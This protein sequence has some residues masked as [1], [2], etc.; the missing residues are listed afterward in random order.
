MPV[1]APGLLQVRRIADA[2]KEAEQ[3][4]VYFYE[5]D[6]ADPEVGGLLG[7]PAESYSCTCL[8]LPVGIALSWPGHGMA[9]YRRKSRGVFT[10]HSPVWPI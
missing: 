7:L 6:P 10:L 2:E 4:S 9:V 3:R 8:A 5:A 1:P